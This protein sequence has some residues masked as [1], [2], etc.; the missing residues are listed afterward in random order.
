MREFKRSLRTHDPRVA[1]KR[2][3][4]VAAE[5]DALIERLEAP[6][7]TTIEAVPADAVTLAPGDA[8]ALAGD[9]W[10]WLLERYAAQPAPP[11]SFSRMAG[12]G[13][14]G[15]TSEP[16]SGQRYQLV[17]ARRLEADGILVEPE[18][19]TIGTDGDP[20]RAD[21]RGSHEPTPIRPDIIVHKRGQRGPNCMAI[22]QDAQL[23]SSAAPSSGQA[24][25]LKASSSHRGGAFQLLP[26]TMAC[27]APRTRAA[28][29]LRRVSERYAGHG[30]A[31]HPLTGG[32]PGCFSISTDMPLTKPRRID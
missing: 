18:Y 32:P 25:W 9:L 20:K 3:A 5:Y 13:P 30:G 19:A 31:A 24:T 16:W 12:N 27:A 22:E 23:G 1:K 11:E 15:A 6:A 7:P 10:R 28:R 2:Y 29:I 17:S 8:L 4:S 21:L 14:W 26:W